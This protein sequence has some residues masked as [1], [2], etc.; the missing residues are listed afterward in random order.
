MS[1][2]EFKPRVVEEVPPP[3]VGRPRMA[4]YD[5]LFNLAV[6]SSPEPVLGAERVPAHRTSTVREALNAR[7][8]LPSNIE[9]KKR[10]TFNVT[11]RMSDGDQ[12]E[13]VDGKRTKPLVDIYVTFVPNPVSGD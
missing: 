9:A 4:I 11:S 8:E 3:R 1:N 6:A 7:L 13:R 10:G 2:I 12:P 5:D